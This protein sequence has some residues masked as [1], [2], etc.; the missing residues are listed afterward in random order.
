MTEGAAEWLEHR[1]NL[2]IKIADECSDPESRARWLAMADEWTTLLA[3]RRLVDVS[4]GG[5][6]L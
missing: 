6:D 2:A 5:T 1:R 3:I 4:G